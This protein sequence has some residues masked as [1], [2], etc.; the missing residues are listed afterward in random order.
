MNVNGNYIR[1][2][3]LSIASLEM[4]MLLVLLGGFA[5][6]ALK[7]RKSTDIKL[8]YMYILAMPYTDTVYRICNV[9]ICEILVLVMIAYDMAAGKLRILINPMTIFMMFFSAVLCASSAASF[10]DITGVLT[11][12]GQHARSMSPLLQNMK[13]WLIIYFASKLMREIK[14]KETVHQL[15][16]IF[17]ISGNIDA[18]ATIL[19]VFFYKMGFAVN[20]IFEM[21]NFPRAK[22]LSHEPGTNAFI[23]MTAMAVSGL[24]VSYGMIKIHKKSL[25]LQMTAFVFCFSSGAIPIFALFCLLF[26]ARMTK[27]GCIAKKL[28]YM[29]FFA[30]VCVFAGVLYLHMS[31]SSQIISYAAEKVNMLLSDYLNRTNFSGRGADIQMLDNLGGNLG[32][33]FGTGAFTSTI[34]FPGLPCTNMY[35]ILLCEIGAAGCLLLI[36][37]FLYFYA[38]FRRYGKRAVEQE[39]YINIILY[40]IVFF[41]VIA[42]IRVLFFHQIWFILSVYFIICRCA[43]DEYKMGRREYTAQ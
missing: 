30:A 26:L 8:I 9:Q 43:D 31:G 13:F 18:A 24:S 1:A 17:R 41:V 42:W 28:F 11:G 35:I 40:A 23:L 27:R 20:G 5:Y 33:V 37:G 3:S 29:V 32:L 22:G 15:M 12:F 14:T 6:I 36:T 38:A 16:E 34:L 19:Q 21:L 25:A 2:E 7:G 39:Y 10:L 4:C